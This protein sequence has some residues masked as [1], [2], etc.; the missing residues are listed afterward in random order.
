MAGNGGRKPYLVVKA[1]GQLA[2][3]R[4]ELNQDVHV[5]GRFGDIRLASPDV[6]KRHAELR[7]GSDGVWLN[8]LHSSNGVLHNGVRLAPDRPVRLAEGDLLQCGSVQLVFHGNGHGNGYG[9]GYGVTDLRDHRRRRAA[10]PDLPTGPV[11]HADPPPVDDDARSSS[12]RFLAAATQLDPWFADVVVQQVVNEPYRAL[13]PVFGADLGVVTRWALAARRRRLARDL[14]LLA[15]LLCVLALIGFGVRAH[16]GEFQSDQPRVD[17]QPYALGALPALLLGWSAV[18]VDIWVTEHLVLRRRLAAHHY[19][20]AEAPDPLSSRVRERLTAVAE[21]P[22]GNLIVCSHYYPF[23][24]SG[25]QVDEWDMPIDIRKG[26]V[27]PE[28]GRRAPRPFATGELYD[29]LVAAARGIGLNNL[30][31]EERLFVDGLNVA[32]DRRLLPTR[33]QP[34]LTR[35]DPHVMR[36]MPD[37]LGATRRSYVSIEI[38]AWSGQLVV[39]MYLRAVQVHGTLYLEWSAYALLPMLP[40]YYAVDRLPHRTAA[41][42]AVRAGVQALARLL[43]ALLGAPRALARR[44]FSARAAAAHR[45]RQRR[46]IRGGYQFDYGAQHSIR[47]F[48]CGLDEGTYFLGR[49]LS[50]ALATT[51]QH[52]LNTVGDFLE[53]HGIDSENFQRQQQNL[54]QNFTTNNDYSVKAKHISGGAIAPGGRANASGAGGGQ[55]AA[56]SAPRG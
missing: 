53:A 25:F 44:A 10:D 48:A 18:A 29:V 14:V 7:L 39:T 21:R 26:T 22:A 5:L 50:R 52:L 43:P 55:R 9:N 47:E 36:A 28:G 11:R 31:V 23:A 32:L 17:W 1:P 35:V 2:G 3:T 45:R 6:S 54:V 37:G 19:Q 41:G 30:R 27:R 42:S 34:P 20:P 56:S 8:D 16:I 15:L 38:P 46:L 24:G 40:Q 12:T 33:D 13:A 49:D 51:Q 4:W